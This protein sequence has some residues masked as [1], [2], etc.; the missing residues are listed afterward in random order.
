MPRR[1]PITNAQKAALRQQRALYPNKS[2]KELREWF[3]LEFNQPIAPSSVSEILSA[4]YQ[5]LDEPTA[6]LQ[7]KKRR[8]QHWPELE[9]ALF[10]WIKG[11]EG[12]VPIT[13]EVIREKARF[14]WSNLPAY[15]GQDM[16]TFSNGWLTSFQQRTGIRDSRLHGEEGSL[17]EIT[18]SQMIPIRQ[19]LSGYHPQDIF[20]CDETALFWK[21]VPDRSLTTRQLPG[22]RKEKARITAHFCCNSDGSER[23]PIWYI[24]TARAPRAF[25]AAGINIRNLNLVWRHNGKA[26]M[27]AKIMEEWL[28]W[29]DS[30]MAGRRVVLLMDNFSAHESAV[31]A[32]N[33]SSSLLENVLIIWLPANSTTRYQPLDQG[34]IH[35]W[36]AYWK[37]QWVFYLIQQYDAG[38]NPLATMNV[39]KALRW[40]IQAWDI[41]V[42]K[43]TIENCFTKALEGQYYELVPD[44][45]AIS[46]LSQGLQHL[47]ISSPI[48]DLMDIRQFLNP[49]EEK[50]EDTIED[51]DTQV[52]AQF[53]PE[54][55]V[56]SDEEVEPTPKIPINEALTALNCLR[57]YEEQQEMGNTSLIQAL[58]R[59]E[60]AIISRRMTIAQQ[61]DIRSFFRS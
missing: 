26:W 18:E 16:P 6:K 52:L 61:Q 44:L 60:R 34:I 13:G 5:S 19:V 54:V 30:R 12:R 32:I 29:F 14:F 11:A 22:R 7:H 3:L 51:L 59:Q 33:K 37:K 40:G 46:E 2:N 36:K 41:D 10:E 9:D 39:L 21:R 49:V 43:Q 55:E 35:S 45:G 25:Q 27:T 1:T 50:V 20:N 48:T 53:D 58:D 24:G 42:K 17:S 8:L 57:L 28:R 4:R 47:Q 15:S 38:H 23:L 31:Q 56:E